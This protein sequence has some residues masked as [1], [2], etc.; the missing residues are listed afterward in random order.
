[1]KS[2]GK[3]NGMF[4]LG[5]RGCKKK[6]KSSDDLCSE[7]GDINNDCMKTYAIKAIQPQRKI[8]RQAL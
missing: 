1:M 5:L 3:D 8:R 7:M 4:L 6:R 2:D